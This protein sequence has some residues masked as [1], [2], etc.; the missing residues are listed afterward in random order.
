M[1]SI[2]IYLPGPPPAPHRQVT[3]VT[4]DGRMSFTVPLLMSLGLDDLAARWS[5]IGRPARQDLTP[6]VG[7]GTA[8]AT[9]EVLVGG[10]DLTTSAEP[11]LQRLAAIANYDQPVVVNTGQMSRYSRSGTWVIEGM[12]VE[13]IVHVQGSN[14]IAR[15]R[16][17]LTV[18]AALTPAQA[19]AL[20]I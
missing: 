5:R 16:V 1:G 10:E 14:D 18:S 3:I 7:D 11:S 6:H 12:D 8:G 19:Q 13:D 9:L 4:V 17:T 15:A 20:G 2:D